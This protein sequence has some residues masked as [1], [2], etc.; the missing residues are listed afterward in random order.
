MTQYYSAIVLAAGLGKRL[1]P[2]TEIEPKAL[3]KVCGKPLIEYVF[4][5][6]KNPSIKK[7]NVVGGCKSDVLRSYLKENHPEVHFIKNENYTRGNILSLMSAM[8]ELN[9]PFILTNVDHIYPPKM[10][11]KFLQSEG[12]VVAAVDFERTLGVDD[13]KVKLNGRNEIKFISKK[14]ANFDC[15]YIGTTI[16]RKDGIRYYHKAFENVLEKRGDE[17]CVEEIL[18]ELSDLKQSPLICNMDGFRWFEI[19]DSA[20][21]VLAEKY[22]PKYAYLYPSMTYFTKKEIPW[23]GEQTQL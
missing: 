8:N 10:L 11:A 6:L 7:I 14:L 5:F 3:V 4:E 23:V 21:L 15:G 18:Q 20:D 22:L 2:L 12:S 17:A 13:M 1:N 19:D 16:C 9:E